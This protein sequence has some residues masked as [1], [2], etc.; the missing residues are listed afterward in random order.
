MKFNLLIYLKIFLV[1]QFSIYSQGYTYSFPIPLEN[2]D[3][4]FPKNMQ[5]QN[6]SEVTKKRI[7]VTYFGPYFKIKDKVV[8][9]VDENASKIV[10]NGLTE[11]FN[12]E[13]Y[14]VDLCA[15][16]TEYF[17]STKQ[18][19]DCLKSKNYNYDLIIGLGQYHKCNLKVEEYVYNKDSSKAPDNAGVIRRRKNQRKWGK[20][21]YK[22]SFIP[23]SSYLEEVDQELVVE[24]T[25]PGRYVCNHYGYG[26]SRYL[27]ETKTKFS[28]VHVGNMECENHSELSRVLSELIKYNL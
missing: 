16:D 20:R 3:I 22:V 23:D 7:L 12:N 5:D 9:P 17:V 27:R 15:L 1:S 11:H 14:Q 19:K 24:S 8:L 6:R 28:F 25:N 10:A 4:Y 26:I 18:A 13:L 21:K 2:E